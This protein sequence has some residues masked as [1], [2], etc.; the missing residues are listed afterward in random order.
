[1][2][3]ALDD[4]RKVKGPYAIWSCQ[5]SYLIH[6]RIILSFQVQ[7]KCQDITFFGT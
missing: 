4:N 1:M 7:G 3:M 6:N 5:F 2:L